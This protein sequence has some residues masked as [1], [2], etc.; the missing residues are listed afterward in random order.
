MAEE[1]ERRGWLQRT[2]YIF[3][4]VTFTPWS[5]IHVVVADNRRRL[6]IE[7]LRYI[8]PQNFTRVVERGG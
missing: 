6:I 4:N 1:K 2:S 8:G 3:R 5:I 7:V